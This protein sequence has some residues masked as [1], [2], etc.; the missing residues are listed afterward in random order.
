MCSCD[1]CYPEKTVTSPPPEEQLDIQGPTG[2]TLFDRARVWALEADALTKLQGSMDELL[3]HI[4]HAGDD[5]LLA[6]LGALILE[7]AVD[8]LAAA[9]LP[10]YRDIRDNSDFSFSMRTD[11]ARAMR[12]VPQ[13]LFAAV[14]AV[15]GIRNDFAH[16]LEF[17]LFSDLKP[18]R[19]SAVRDRLREFGPHLE[20][21]RS[22]YQA[23]AQLVS[24]CALALL[25]YASHVEI[26][27]AAI[28]KPEFLERLAAY[29]Q[30]GHT[31]S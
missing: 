31:W 21:G 29:A 9:M 30:K 4:A 15:R 27:N 3:G 22:D 7:N 1:R 17:S 10:G 8:R 20:K 23:V 16:N 26:L 12:L 5:R 13:R 2:E 14:D 18:G 24:N 19:M 25:V 11:V 28:R 6:L